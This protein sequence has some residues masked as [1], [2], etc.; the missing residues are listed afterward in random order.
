MGVK[1]EQVIEQVTEIY[2]KIKIPT[3]PGLGLKIDPEIITKAEK[4]KSI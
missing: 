3:A 4:N 2:Y 1:T